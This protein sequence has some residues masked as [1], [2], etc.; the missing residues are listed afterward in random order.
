MRITVEAAVLECRPVND[1][2]V[3]IGVGVPRRVFTVAVGP[4]SLRGG[5][6]CLLEA[7]IV[8]GTAKRGRVGCPGVSFRGVPASA[9]AANAGWM[10]TG[11]QSLSS[12][13]V[14]MA[15]VE[16]F[17]PRTVAVHPRGER[18]QG[19]GRG[20]AWRAGDVVGLGGAEHARKCRP[21]QPAHE[22]STPEETAQG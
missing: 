11:K 20:H 8:V 2:P 10:R 17:S 14:S 13:C 16:E 6:P 4:I 18:L 3:D 19:L 9:G 12:R 1:G 7:E 21:S 15:P 5:Q 22:V